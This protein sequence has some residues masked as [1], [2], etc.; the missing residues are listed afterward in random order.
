[1]NI[2]IA[3][4]QNLHSFARLVYQTPI[5]CSIN[6]P[7]FIVMNFM[8]TSFSLR[9][10]RLLLMG[11]LISQSALIKAQVYLSENFNSSA[12]GV[13]FPAGWQSDMN[14]G[15]NTEWKI[16]AYPFTK[17]AVNLQSSNFIICDAD[18]GGSGSTTN[19]TLTS[20]SFNTASANLLLLELSQAYRDYTATPSDSAIIE[21]FN[22]TGWVAV[23]KKNTST[24]NN[25]LTGENILIN[26]SQYKNPNMKIRFRYVGEWPWFWAIDGI[27]IFQPA[28]NDVGV[29]GILSPSGSCGLSASSPIKVQLSNFGSAQQNSITVK[30]RINAGNVVTET[31]NG[32]LSPGSTQEFT[33]TTPGN[34]S[35]PGVYSIDAWTALS[36]DVTINNDSTK[37]YKVTK[38]SSSFGNLSFSNYNG[39]NLSTLYPGWREAGGLNPD[40]ITSTFR[41]SEDLQTSAFQTKTATVNLFT[42][43]RKEWLVSPP[44]VPTEISGLAFRAAV[45]QWLTSAPDQMG[46]DDVVRVMVTTNCG[47]SWTPLK[48][49]DRNS[50]LPSTLTNQTVS[51]VQFAGNEIQLAFYATDGTVDD[52][53]DYDF[54][55]DSIRIT[56]LPPNELAIGNI[57]S[58]VS[59][60]SV[61]NAQVKVRIFN[62]GTNNQTNFPVCVRINGQT[63]CQNFPGT[64]NAGANA[65][66]TFTGLP[67]LSSPGD[68]N[69]RAFVNLSNDFDRSNDTTSNYFFQ[70][71]PNVTSYPY[72]QSFETNNGGW[73]PGGTFSSWILGTPNKSVIKGAGSGTKAYATGGLG[74]ESYNVN[75]KSWV[76]GPCMDFSSLQ[77]PMFEMKAWWASEFSEDGA[78]LQASIDGG[79][80]WT[81]VGGIN[82][83]SNWYNDNTVSGL[84]SLGS[85][86]FLGWTGGLNDAF[87]SNGWVTVKNDLK[88]LGG[89]SSV[90]LRIAFGAGGNVVGDGFAF[91]DIRIYEKPDRDLAIVSFDRPR[92]SGCGMTDTSKIQIRVKN[93]GKLPVTNPSFGYRRLPFGTDVSGNAVASIDTNAFYT[94]TFSQNE[95]LSSIGTY[96]LRGWVGLSND[97]QRSN[98][99]IRKASFTK[100]ALFTDTIKFQQYNGVNLPVLYNGW[101]SQ[102]G[103]P[104]P[105]GNVTQW[106]GA[107]ITQRTFYGKNVARILM[108]DANVASWILGPAYQIQNNAFLNFEV[109]TTQSFDTVNVSGGGFNGTDDKL[110]VMVS[111]NCGDSWT[112]VFAVK[113]GDGVTR[114]FKRFKANLS[115]FSGKEIRIALWATTFP[116]N[117]P[118]NYDLLVDN[119]FMETLD[120]FDGG[121]SAISSPLISCGLTESVQVKVNVK[122]FGAQPISNFPVYYKI[123]QLNPVNETFT[124]T[125]APGTTAEYIFAEPAN[126][127][128]SQP[129]TLVAG[130]NLA[131]DNN[132]INN[133]SAID[134]VKVIAPFPPTSLSGYTGANLQTVWAGWYEAKGS[135]P[136]EGNASWT[137]ATFSGQ[138][139]I[140]VNLAGNNKIDWILSPGIKIGT[141][142]FLKFRAGLFQQNGTGPAQFDVDDSVTVM[143]STNCGATWSKL[144]KIGKTTV[145][146]LTNNMQPYS[147]SLSAYNNQEIRLG[148]RARDGVRIDFVSDLYLS[149][150]EIVS[151]IQLDASPFQINFSPSISTSGN[152]IHFVKDSTYSVSAT[153]SNFGSQ[154]ISDVPVAVQFNSENLLLDS[155]LPGPINPGQSV[156]V[157]LGTFVPSVNGAIYRARLYTSLNGDEAIGNDTLAFN[158][159]VFPITP[160]GNL[161]V[162]AQPLVY[163]NPTS[164]WINISLPEESLFPTF[165]LSDLVGKQ[166]VLPEGRVGINTTAFNLNHLPSGLY[167]LE[168]R[169]PDRVFRYRLKKE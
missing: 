165:Y 27:K 59:G 85:N 30:Y 62:E 33:F 136:V 151:S 57:T 61:S 132:V 42:S 124:Q 64:L 129:Y 77:K 17:Y 22:G 98:D 127:S 32:S 65:E 24:P 168:A 81:T 112:E 74:N 90:R 167:W 48:T 108:A 75:E 109:A 110:R 149:Q 11:I 14:G 142:N 78:I 133:I 125:L 7:N 86:P 113:A 121:V 117:D 99:T 9:H 63:T 119:I 144:F 13:A 2:I 164:D 70:N 141:N 102:D 40:G 58:P 72:S 49:F 43:S 1:M 134:L 138:T 41:A 153:I 143:V 50:N 158:Y 96:D 19:S 154:V 47:A 38:G 135:A 88:G 79:A 87:G 3:A 66:F 123:N 80:S 25:G 67:A 76:L 12:P 147:V 28:A 71:I 122:N 45:T 53:E 83:V 6:N 120:P 68:F 31:F 36:G 73:I 4:F 139:A 162:S 128:L 103:N 106:L 169:Y 10:L 37:N 44:V 92:P 55:L 101:S 105:V 46:S 137:N 15:P 161:Q 100:R 21:I 93:V 16:V 146:G 150:I 34:F 84:S 82:D 126:L 116:N 5:S 157:V 145:P 54:H 159:R 155:V 163:P 26:I 69:I 152:F 18:A 8:T 39:E 140:K 23:Q 91:D 130:T 35:T 107:Y 89:E 20:S 52:P 118:V 115:A 104:L 29:T 131:N 60:C 97:A 94:Y 95:N 56:N 51:L 114:N 111:S 156:D 148:F 166:L 160:I